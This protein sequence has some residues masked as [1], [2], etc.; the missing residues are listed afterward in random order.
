MQSLSKYQWH[1]H[2]TRTNNPKI[3]IEPQKTQNSQSRK[4]EERNWRYHAPRFETILQYHSNQNSMVLA[5][6]QTH[7]SMEQ[8][9]EPRYK[10]TTYGQLIFD[11]GGKNIL[12]GKDSLVSKWYWESWTAACKSMKLEHTLTPCAKIN[13]K[14]LKDEHKT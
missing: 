10:P 9:R 4:K 1:F 5:Q 8:N 11:K 6:K 12:W 7:G 14:W 13:S 2:K 3:C